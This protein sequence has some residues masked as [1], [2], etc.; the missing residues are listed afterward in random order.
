MTK[1]NN[2][3]RPFRF[4]LV[5]TRHRPLVEWLI[6]ENYIDETTPVVEHAHAG[7]SKA[8][9]VPTEG[10]Y[11]VLADHRLIIQREFKTE[12]A[13]QA[14]ALAYN[15]ANVRGKHVLGVLPHHL[16]AA[17]AS[18]TEVQLD[19]TLEDR[20]A[21]QAGD[22]DVEAVARAARG[23]HTYVVQRYDAETAL[24]IAI[25]RAIKHT[26]QYDFRVMFGTYTDTEGQHIRI[27]EVSLQSSADVR[28]QTGEWIPGP[29][30]SY[31]GSWQPA[32]ET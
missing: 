12:A 31:R 18:I 29:R 9:V 10:G 3:F 30:H 13:A 22:V 19:W 1:F 5:V 11:E 23:L 4:D 25:A 16:S 6:R 17:A 28:I 2:P 8:R 20:K 32:I 7:A 15:N 14:F 26:A 27:D 24:P 21:M